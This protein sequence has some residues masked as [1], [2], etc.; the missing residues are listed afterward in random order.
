MR[1]TGGLVATMKRVSQYRPVRLNAVGV[2]GARGYL[3]DAAVA[4]GGQCRVPGS[5]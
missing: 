5:K 2:E 3:K 4:T 1:E